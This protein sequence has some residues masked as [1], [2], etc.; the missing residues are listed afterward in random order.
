M[1]APKDAFAIIVPLAKPLQVTW[2]DVAPIVTSRGS[3]MVTV[4]AAVQK[5]V[6]LP[7]GTLASIK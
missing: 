2:V 5:P 6:L 1:E 7:L 4:A 3:E